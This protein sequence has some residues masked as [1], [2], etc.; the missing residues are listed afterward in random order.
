MRL[1]V[2]AEAKLALLL[3]GVLLGEARLAPPEGDLGLVEVDLEVGGDVEVGEEE[4]G[5]WLHLPL[6]EGVLNWPP[7]DDW[8]VVAEGGGEL[9]LEENDAVEEHG[10]DEVGSAGQDVSCF[11]GE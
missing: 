6:E 8:P 2:E 7:D 10:V 9:L 3:G 4:G 1:K 11:L 5:G